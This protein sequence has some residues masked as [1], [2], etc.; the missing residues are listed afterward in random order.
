MERQ[1]E[2]LAFASHAEHP[3]LSNGLMAATGTPDAMKN[4]V[5]LQENQNNVDARKAQLE[6]TAEYRQESLDQRKD[7]QA[8]LAQSRADNQ[9]RA[10]MPQ[11]GGLASRAQTPEDY[12]RAYTQAEAIAQRIGPKYHASD[13]GLLD[14]SDWQPGTVQGTTAGQQLNSSDKGQQRQVSVGNNRA[15]NAARVQSARISAGSKLPTEASQVD[16]IRQKVNNGETLNAGDQAV[17][18]KQTNI[19][20]SSGASGLHPATTKAAGPTAAQYSHTATGPG[21]KKMGWNGKAWVPI[22]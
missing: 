22:N 21:G 20:K 15:T 17:W 14:P 13:F 2:G 19:K 5:S 16:Q 11:I 3:E 7:N 12:T 18:D 10:L 4:V 6:A 1:Q 9:V 8:A